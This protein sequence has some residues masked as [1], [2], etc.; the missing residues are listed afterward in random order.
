MGQRDSLQLR[1]AAAVR[2]KIGDRCIR[3]QQTLIHEADAQQ[4]D[5]RF[6]DGSGAEI[7]GFIGDQVGVNGFGENGGFV[8]SRS[9]ADSGAGY[10][11]AAQNCRKRLFRGQGMAGNRGDRVLRNGRRK[12]GQGQTV[13]EILSFGGRHR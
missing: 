5:G 13:Q 2:Q 3:I 8:R 7:R 9:E 10:M 12:H 4:G 11:I 6:R 1:K